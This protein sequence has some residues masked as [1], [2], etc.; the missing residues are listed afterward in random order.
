MKA[1]TWTPTAL[2]RCLKSSFS[3]RAATAASERRPRRLRPAAAAAGSSAD[4]IAV[5][6]SSASVIDLAGGVARAGA[7]RFE[8]QTQSVTSSTLP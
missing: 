5:A 6:G 2:Q 7:C 1:S 3:C 4:V 8:L